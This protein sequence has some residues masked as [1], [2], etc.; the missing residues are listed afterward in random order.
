MVTAK[1]IANLPAEQDEEGASI[2]TRPLTEQPYWNIE[3]ARIGKTRNVKVELIVNGKPVDSKEILANGQWKDVSF[4]YPVDH[5]SWVALRI[6]P[7]VHTNPIFVLV[8]GK[9]IHELK[10]AEWCRKAVDQ[11]WKMKQPKIRPTEQ[12]SAEEAYNKARKVYDQI[13]ADSSKN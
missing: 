1:V 9:P 4:D 10:S 7:T 12:A 2:A 13:T 5:S 11:C 8:D 6:F 3:R